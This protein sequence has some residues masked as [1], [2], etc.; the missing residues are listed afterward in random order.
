MLAKINMK[1]STS[2][3]RFEVTG[4]HKKACNSWTK[5]SRNDK[6]SQEEWKLYKAGEGVL[7]K[8][9]MGLIGTSLYLQEKGY[10]EKRIDSD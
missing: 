9:K 3:A 7:V 2:E 1:I 6:I 4:A 8:N 5:K 10:I